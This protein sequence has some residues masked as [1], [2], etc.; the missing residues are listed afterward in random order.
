[1]TT[2]WDT[3]GTEVVKALSAER[4]A[5]GAVA[6][7]LALTLVVVTDQRSVDEAET[8]ATTAASAH[9]CR[10]LFV[11][12]RHTEAPDPRLDAEVLVGDRLGPG[13]AV[14]MRMYGR[15]ALHAESVVLPLLAPDAPVVTWWHDAP[16]DKIAYDPLG[17][18]AD[19]R[20]TDVMRCSDPLK[21]LQ[22]R[23]ED[24]APGDT[25]LAWA[26]ITG[27]RSL[28]AASYDSMSGTP[29]SA[30]VTG[31]AHPSTALMI[32]WLRSRLNIAVEL[33]QTRDSFMKQVKVVLDDDT[34][35]VT[36]HDRRSAVL[37]RSDQGDRVQPL[38]TRD[39]GDLLA[40]EVKRLDA[41]GVYAEALEAWTGVKGLAQRSPLRTHIWRDPMQEAAGTDTP[42]SDANPG[43]SGTAG[44]QGAAQERPPGAPARRGGRT[45]TGGASAARG[46]TKP[47]AA[48][49]ESNG[50][51]ASTPADQA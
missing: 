21:G 43:T 7:G 29:R 31:P 42:A 10:T 46:D 33:D 4:R 25:D 12:R 37:H 18:F 24:Y 1:M 49:S 6:F 20:L 36:R 45:R 44:A 48:V 9:P 38:A 40:E 39:L 35:M 3:S 30:T 47:A 5:A 26:N 8:A 17:V 41:D 22:Q 15:L 32:G 23:A 16:P 28:I 14:V 50:A 27:W 51:A 13:E 19:R 11:V 34:L 2:L